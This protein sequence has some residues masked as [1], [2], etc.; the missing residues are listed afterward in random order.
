MARKHMM[1]R[2]TSSVGVTTREF[3]SGFLWQRQSH[4]GCGCWRGMHSRQSKTFHSITAHCQKAAHKDERI[5]KYSC[6]ACAV[7]V[8]YVDQHC[9]NPGCPASSDVGNTI[10]TKTKTKSRLR[11]SRY[12]VETPQKWSSPVRGS[13][14]TLHC[15]RYTDSEGQS[16]L[17]PCY[18]HICASSPWWHY[19]VTSLKCPGSV[20]LDAVT[21]QWN[22]LQPLINYLV[23]TTLTDTKTRLPASLPRSTQD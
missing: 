2:W 18:G 15:Q 11:G 1:Q 3:H 8:L 10:S 4:Q 21:S 6:C 16:S 12:G 22:K 17:E 14:H 20:L 19:R 9:S 23:K 5:V 7:Q 13:V